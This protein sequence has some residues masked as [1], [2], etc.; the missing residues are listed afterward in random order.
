[1]L[2]PAAGAASAT[3]ALSLRGA[4]DAEAAAWLG[5]TVAVDDEVAMGVGG[6]EGAAQRSRGWEQREQLLD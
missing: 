3:V 4:V 5:S 1:M 6:E 2:G